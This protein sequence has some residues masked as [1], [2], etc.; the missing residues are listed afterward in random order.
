MISDVLVP[1]TVSILR[2]NAPCTGLVLHSH[3]GEV[4]EYG[5]EVASVDSL[6]ISSTFSSA[7]D[8]VMTWEGAMKSILTEDS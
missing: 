8:F 6:K 4:G 7:L 2:L 1:V 3:P 5:S